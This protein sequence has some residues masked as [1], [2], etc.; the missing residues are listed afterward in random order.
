[1]AVKVEGE[2]GYAPPYVLAMGPNGKLYG[3][4][5]GH[6]GIME[7]D[8]DRITKAP[9]PEVA[10]R[11]AAP[12]SPEGLPVQDV[13]AGVFGKDGRFYYPLNTTGPLAP[14]GKPEAHL[15]V[16]RF[17]PAT[18]KS[19]TVGIPEVVGLDEEKVKHVYTRRA[20]Y[21]LQYM[22]GAAVGADGTLFLMAI[23]PQLNVA[24]FPKL[25]APK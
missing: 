13:H 11:N 10:M 20:T 22:Q 19:E 12:T 9:F 24:C 3:A 7:F 4:V 2:V 18:R 14:G 6:A 17:D 1:M 23:Y 8:I 21:K 15:R 25:T 16:M 5:A